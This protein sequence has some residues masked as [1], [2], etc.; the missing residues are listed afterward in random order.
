MFSLPP[1]LMHKL[2]GEP[3]GGSSNALVQVMAELCLSIEEM[4]EEGKN[5]G[6]AEKFFA[7]LVNSTDTLPVSLQDTA[8]W[9]R[10]PRLPTRRSAW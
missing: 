3:V 2:A 1:S 5:I 9:S 4:F 7:L 6:A 10:V 8:N